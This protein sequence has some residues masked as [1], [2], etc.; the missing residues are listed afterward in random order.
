RFVKQKMNIPE[1]LE[2]PS[3]FYKVWNREAIN[4]PWVHK[5]E[6]AFGYDW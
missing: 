2:S 5:A 4:E 6:R 3:A 1:A